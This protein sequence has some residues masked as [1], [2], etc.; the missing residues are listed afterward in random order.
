MSDGADKDRLYSRDEIM[1]ERAEKA[2]LTGE[3]ASCQGLLDTSKAELEE[4]TAERD[5][6]LSGVTALQRHLDGLQKLVLAHENAEAS[7]CPEDV[8]IVEYA[9]AL[10][11]ERDAALTLA[12]PLDRL[13][14]WAKRMVRAD[15]HSP[16]EIIG[17]Y[18]SLREER[19]RFAAALRRVLDEDEA[20]HPGDFIG[21]NPAAC[22]DVVQARAKSEGL[23]EAAKR[24]RE[25]ANSGVGRY[26]G[27]TADEL[28]RMAAQAEKENHA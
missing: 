1:A 6:A 8:G 13:Y 7:V 18:E 21:V 11:K 10:R 24:A 15:L 2:R 5:A 16:L 14:E 25:I 12:E 17:E 20:R 9:K 23:R 27:L 28:D 3:L 26:A 19:D 22:L 4:R